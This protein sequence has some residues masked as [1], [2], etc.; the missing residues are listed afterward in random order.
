M[1]NNLVIMGR[2]VADPVLK[3]TN[4]GNSVVSFRIAVDRMKKGEADFFTVNAWNRTAEFIGQY[5]KKGSLIAI[6]G[7]IQ[8]RTFTDK[9]GN[10]RTVTEIEAEKAD[11]CGGKNDGVTEA[12]SATKPAPANVGGGKEAEESAFYE[13]QKMGGVNRPFVEYDDDADL[14]F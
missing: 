12:S 4:A 1:V 11:F 10:E 2:L 13:Q 7:R 3:S 5:F 6:S 8:N 14:P 9:N